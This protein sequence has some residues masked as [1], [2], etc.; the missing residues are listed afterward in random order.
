MDR[1]SGIVEQWDRWL[2]PEPH[3]TAVVEFVA[4]GRAS[5]VQPDADRPPLLMYEDGGSMVLPLVR[6]DGQ[7]PFYLAGRP[8]EQ[9]DGGH[10]STKYSDVCGSIDEFKRNVTEGAEVLAERRAEI[11]EL[12]D[13][14]RHMIGRMYRRQ[15]EYTAFADRLR[16]IIEELAA[17]E[18]VDRTPADEGLAELELMLDG[19][20]ELGAVERLNELAEQ[21]R[22]VASAQ[23]QRLR[24]HKT[25]ALEILALYREVKGPRD[26]SEDEAEEE[27]QAGDGGES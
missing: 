16:A 26:W 15:R 10:R 27:G 14:I 3:R 11:A 22:A 19:G 1:S 23:E 21:V 13:D 4:R 7:E 12:F 8:A 17:I 18:I 20:E 24:D 9:A 5:I 25:A 6:C 2:P